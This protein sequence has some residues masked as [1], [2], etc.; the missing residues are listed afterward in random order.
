[1]SAPQFDRGLAVGGSP[2]A[3]LALPFLLLSLAACASTPDSTPY[4]ADASMGMIIAR[5]NCASC[6][7]LFLDR[8]SPN[9]N[10]P[11]FREIVNRP[12]MTP[13]LLATWLKDGHNYPSEMGFYLE[14]GK[15]DSLVAYM[16]RQRAVGP[17]S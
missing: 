5:D 10:A 2:V 8:E 14:P 11:P 3:R 7:E 12:G 16:I 13:A 17:A 15:V 4:E 1:M 6:H 9:P